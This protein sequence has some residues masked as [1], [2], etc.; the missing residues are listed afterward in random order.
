MPPMRRGD[1]RPV[2]ILPAQISVL[3]HSEPFDA[4]GPD[5]GEPAGQRGRSNFPLVILEAAVT[6]PFSH[7]KLATL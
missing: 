5:K 3:H 6:V 4:D 7:R 1:G 2:R